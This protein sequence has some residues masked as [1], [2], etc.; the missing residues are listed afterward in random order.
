MD[1]AGF[2]GKTSVWILLSLALKFWKLMLYYVVHMYVPIYE[3][4]MYDSG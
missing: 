4:C 1:I 3:L 2:L